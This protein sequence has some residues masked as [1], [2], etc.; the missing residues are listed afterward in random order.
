[1]KIAIAAQGEKVSAH[2][3]HCEGFLVYKTTG[4]EVLSKTKVSNPGHKPGFLPVFL[5]GMGVEL[6]VA[7][8]MGEHAQ[9][10]FKQNNIAVITGATGDCDIIVADYLKG[11]L[12]S[13]NSVCKE[14]MHSGDC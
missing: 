6:I 9:T 11:Q 12:E 5:D 1:M 7:G 2:F 13:S 4:E 14:H 8:G 3:G 10:L